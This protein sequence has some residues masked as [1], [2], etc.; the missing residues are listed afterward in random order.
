ME[1]NLPI[2]TLMGVMQKAI[3]ITFPLMLE[4]KKDVSKLNGS[5]DYDCG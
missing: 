5:S 4:K 3:A 1:N 2:K